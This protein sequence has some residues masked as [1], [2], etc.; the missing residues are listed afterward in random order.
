MVELIEHV[1]LEQLPLLCENVFG[2]LNPPKIIVTTPNYDFNYYFRLKDPN[3]KFRHPD[4]KYEF[5]QE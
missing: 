4:H 3:F 1:Y 2:F 5:T